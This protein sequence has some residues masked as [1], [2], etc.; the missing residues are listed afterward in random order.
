MLRQSM[1]LHF[2]CEKKLYQVQADLLKAW[3]DA[4]D[5]NKFQVCT[6]L[7]LAIENRLP[8]YYALSAYIKSKI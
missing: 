8:F 1:A 2:N 3:V 4:I 6:P 7:L 5:K